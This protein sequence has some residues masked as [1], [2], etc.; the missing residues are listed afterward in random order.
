MSSTCGKKVKVT[1]FGESHGKAIGVVVEGFPVGEII[2][3]EELGAFMA[4]RSAVGKKLATPRKEP[5]IPQFISGV[6]E[7]RIVS[8]PLCAIIENTNPHSGDYANLKQTPRPGHADFAAMARYGNDV[9]LRG[10]GHFSGRLTAPL[11]VAGGIAK[12][13]LARRG[14]TVTG[15]LLA[16]GGVS[17]VSCVDPQT[18]VS[19]VEETGVAKMMDAAQAALQAGDSVGGLIE[20]TVSGLAAGACGDHMFD[21]LEGRIAQF[22]FGVPAIKGIEFGNGFA[23]AGL[24]G[25]ENNDPFY[26]DQADGKVKTKTNRHGGILG[27]MASGMPI[28]FRV[29][30]KPTPSIFQTQDSV[31]L[32]FDACGRIVNAK[33][34]KLSIRGRHDPCIA[35]RAVP[36]IEAAAA[37][38]VLDALLS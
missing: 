32:Q 18:G 23:C 28:V 11:C 9:D 7:D 3:K 8:S 5:D 19:T 2:D 20:C 1:V 17:G 33:D 15:Q 25:S 29:A 24:R 16:I 21:G 27:G 22:V 30:V 34:T 38:A 31:E 6:V 14:V 37:L 12:Q 26:V 13:I 4:R 36:V 35:I 10:G